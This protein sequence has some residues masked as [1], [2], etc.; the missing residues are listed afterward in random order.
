LDYQREVKGK[1]NVDCAETLNCIG[2]VYN[3]QGDYFKALEYFKES[4]AIQDRV[5]GT[6]SIECIGCLNN[7]GAVYDTLENNS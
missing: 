5:N 7:I 6:K 2:E 3:S 1:E 4:L